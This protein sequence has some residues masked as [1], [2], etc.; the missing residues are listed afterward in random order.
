MPRT[1]FLLLFCIG[2][3][4]GFPV[5]ALGQNNETLTIVTY[6]PSPYGVY[7]NLEVRRGLAVGNI[8]GSSVGSM[9]NLNPGQLFINNSMILNPLLTTPTDSEGKEGQLIYVGGTTNML[10]FHNDTTWVNTTCSAACPGCGSSDGQILSSAP[11]ISTL[12]S[13]STASSVT[14]N[15]SGAYIWNC[16]SSAG[17]TVTFCSAAP[18]LCSGIHTSIQC[19]AAGGTVYNTGSCY[20]CKF[21]SASCPSTWTYVPNWRGYD[22]QVRGDN[23]C[24][25]NGYCCQCVPANYAYTVPAAFGNGIALTQYQSNCCGGYMVNVPQTYTGCY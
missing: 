18:G 13:S 23:S 6:Y 1:V 3:C 8:T 4:A 5:F 7:R 25:Y 15:S 22:S 9:A 17:K 16:S 24:N 19:I 21:H 2:I 12:C 10:K 20:A 14:V 11:A